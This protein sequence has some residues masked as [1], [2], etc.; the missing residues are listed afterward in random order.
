M[1][2]DGWTLATLAEAAH[3]VMGQSPPGNAYN[4]RGEGVPLLNGPTEFGPVHPTPAQWTNVPTKFAEPG[5][6]L[7]C[8]RGSTTGRQ[9]LADQRYCIGRGLAAVREKPGQSLTPFL[10]HV[11]A[12]VADDVLREARGAGSTFPNITSERLYVLAFALPPLG[13]QKKIAAILSSVDDAI[14][15]SQAVI[16]QLGIAKKAMMAE[17]LTRGLP[18]RHTRFKQ[19]EIGEVPASWDVLPL[20]EV[21]ALQ[22]GLAKGKQVERGV[23]LPYLR[24]A[25][26]QDGYVDLSEMKTIVVD[27]RLVD[28]YRVRAGDVLFTEGGDADKLGR[29]C[30]WRGQVEPCL[31]QNHVFA[32]RPN[33][34][35]LTPEFL[36]YWAAGPRGKV[37]FLDC[38]KQTTN[39][40]S[41]NS[42]Q[43]KA[44]PVPIVPREEQEQIVDSLTSLDARLDAD[45]ATRD[46]LRALKS[47]LM[48]VLLTG[49]VR[50]R[51]DEDMA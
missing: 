22:T 10:R 24:V 15:A 40:A 33:V 25:N 1:T 42:T 45:R 49:E 18:G 9:N 23:E 32:V 5:D 46:A 35:R 51:T 2:P 48:S 43:L 36:A 37:Y 20:A 50:V 12:E 41:I 39:L 34:E 47:A 30:V 38:A 7:F 6:V 14:E 31:H 3:V 44:L 17:F 29:G 19:T 28:R 27:E 26:V 4:T 16:N 21:A 11:L 13:E 8:V